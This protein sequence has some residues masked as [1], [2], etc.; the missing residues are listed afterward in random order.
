[1][2]YERKKA[3][4]KNRSKKTFYEMA[5]DCNEYVREDTVINCKTIHKMFENDFLM[6]NKRKKMCITEIASRTGLRMGS[7]TPAVNILCYMRKPVLRKFGLVRKR[8]NN[9]PV[10]M[11]MVILRKPPKS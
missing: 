5:N 9:K 8:V 3:V 7:I 2:I 11:T 10:T 1:M 6:T 4:Y